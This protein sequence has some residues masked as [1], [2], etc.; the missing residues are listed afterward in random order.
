MS[1]NW[2]SIGSGN[3]LSPIDSAPSHYLNQCSFI[4]N[5]TLWKKIQWNSNKNAKFSFKKIYMKMSSAKWRPFCPRGDELNSLI[6]KVLDVTYKVYRICTKYPC[7]TIT[8][9][10]LDQDKCHII[11]VICWRLVRSSLCKNIIFCSCT[12]KW[13][14]NIHFKW[15]QIFTSLIQA[16]INRLF[17]AICRGLTLIEL[18]FVL[19]TKFKKQLVCNMGV[20]D[21]FLEV[22]CFIDY[23][24]ETPNFVLSPK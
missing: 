3:G 23:N 17:C 20:V 14:Q 9:I 21:F 1:V 12:C 15:V 22:T 19:N 6:W 2:I 5:W 16:M 7:D 11:K 13:V 8:M 10:T 24:F 4:V 18:W